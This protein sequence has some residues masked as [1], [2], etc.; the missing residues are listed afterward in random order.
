MIEGVSGLLAIHPDHERPT[1]EPSK[2]QL[3]WPNG[4]I[5]QM[6]AADEYET[7]RGP[8][9]DAAWCDELCRWRKPQ[10]AWDMLQLALRLGDNPQAVITTTPRASKL[11][12][13]PRH[14]S[15]HRRHP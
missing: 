8:Q 14:R 4:S 2:N 10:A 13:T 7:L 12:K 11:L 6:F 15:K 3:V 9:F 5:A 1:F